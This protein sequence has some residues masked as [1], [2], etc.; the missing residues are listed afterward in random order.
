LVGRENIAMHAL[1]SG[2][3]NVRRTFILV[4][5]GLGAIVA[6]LAWPIATFASPAPAVQHVALVL[7]LCVAV[8]TPVVAWA[9]AN[10]T[11]LRV[12][13]RTGSDFVSNTIAVWL[14]QIPVA[15][16]GCVLFQAPGAFVG[17]AG[18][19][20]C[21]ALISQQQIRAILVQEP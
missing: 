13:R 16:L 14:V 6:I 17:L 9:Y 18:Y 20:L 12:G 15:F 7:I 8:L 10:V 11:I 5:L 3:G 21:R 19:W 1:V 4:G 2:S